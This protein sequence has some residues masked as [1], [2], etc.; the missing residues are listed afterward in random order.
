MDYLPS[1]EDKEFWE[2][3]LKR[4]VD[5]NDHFAGDNGNIWG[6]FKHCLQTQNRFFFQNALVPL[7][8]DRYMQNM[9]LLSADTKLYRARIDK[10]RTYEKQCWCTKDLF[11]VQ[12]SKEKE[13]GK[14]TVDEVFLNICNRRIESI[15]RE[16][17]YQ[18][19][20]ERK[21]EG[22][23][24][25]NAKESGAPPCHMVDVGRCNPEHVSFL[26]AAND[27]HTAVAEVRPF[28]R[29]SVSVATLK[30]KKKLKLVDFYY[31]FD[32]QGV[33]I[34]KDSFMHK[35]RSEFSFVNKGN[36]EEYLITQYL[37][38]LAQN[39]GFDGI[40]FRSSL[41]QE[42]TNYVIFDNSN[43]IPIT[44]K[45]FIIPKITYSLIPILD[46]E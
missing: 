34:I 37:T 26:Y 43:C 17:E 10:E 25:F 32:E 18:E 14:N 40:R 46:E 27:K 2:E 12:K 36:K 30:V 38:L 9:Y 41:V 1:F 13:E 28:I 11:D 33:I 15:R 3:E 16:P 45:V 21:K 35:L 24:G 44:S 29:D 23:E 4:C 5:C 20:L 42:G 8:I 39:V 22:F 7:I 19:F 6:Y 31:E